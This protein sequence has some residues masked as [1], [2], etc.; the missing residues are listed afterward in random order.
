[1]DLN[2]MS[3]MMGKDGQPDMSSIMSMFGG[4]NHAS[5]ETGLGPNTPLYI[6]KKIS[7]ITGLS[8]GFSDK[9]TTNT[10]G[11]NPDTHIMEDCMLLE[12]PK[13]IY[14][15]YTIT[16][17][18]APIII[19]ECAPK[20]EILCS[21]GYKSISELNKGDKIQ[22]TI[23]NLNTDNSFVEDME[24]SNVDKSRQFYGIQTPVYK[25]NTQ[26]SNMFVP[27][28]YPDDNMMYLINFR[29]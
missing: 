10:I 18:I 28:Y 26:Y 17:E 7:S 5:S 22:V 25:F 2:N 9:V 20:S 8:I 23:I 14:V 4:M 1:M 29:L 16:V 24:I 11:I 12:A 21:D 6:D 19:F 15:D 3:S 27:F 13:Q